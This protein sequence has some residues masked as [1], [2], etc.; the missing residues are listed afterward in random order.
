MSGTCPGRA[1]GISL[2]AGSCAGLISDVR[3][4]V[5]SLMTKSRVRSASLSL[6]VG[7]SSRRARIT[8]APMR[9]PRRK[10]ESSLRMHIWSVLGKI[11]KPQPLSDFRRSEI[12][13]PYYRITRA[14]DFQ[15]QTQVTKCEC[16]CQEQKLVLTVPVRLLRVSISS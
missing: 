7:R 8:D 13:A 16:V 14:S 1:S 4:A 3:S 2:C 15:T 5:H 6:L 10:E 9:Q 12:G 11:K